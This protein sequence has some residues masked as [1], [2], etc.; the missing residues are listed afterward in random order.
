V[1]LT[2]A[3]LQEGSVRRPPLAPWKVLRWQGQASTGSVAG[4]DVFAS[5]AAN[6]V[7]PM[8]AAVGGRG[9]SATLASPPPNPT[10]LAGVV[11]S[12]VKVVKSVQMGMVVQEQLSWFGPD[13]ALKGV[14]H[15]ESV[16]PPPPAIE[17][18]RLTMGTG[19]NTRA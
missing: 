7:P 10:L 5:E 9:I 1:T 2:L 13:L 19:A 4:S 14:L 18:S 15:Q 6:N 11:L 12:K 3:V 8:S 16:A 17:A